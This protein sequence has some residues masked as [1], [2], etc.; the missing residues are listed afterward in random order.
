MSLNISY[1]LV[2]S[3]VG[4]IFCCQLIFPIFFYFLLLSSVVSCL[5]LSDVF[6]YLPLYLAVFYW[7]QLLYFAITWSFLP[8][9]LP[10][11]VFCCLSCLLLSADVFNCLQ[12][13]PDIFCQLLV[14]S[15]FIC[16]LPMSHVSCCH[17]IFPTFFSLFL[18]YCFLLISFI[19]FWYLLMTVGVFC[20][21][22][23]AS[24][25]FW[26]LLLS[27]AILSGILLS[28]VEDRFNKNAK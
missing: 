28:F 5:L 7:L 16:C 13:P 2:L 10:S 20:C 11:V 23:M 24:A 1:C 4:L 12:Q 3:S 21:L 18:V 9:L 15:V 17:N 22:L 27:G 25:V 14:S 19:V 6:K 26:W 8:F